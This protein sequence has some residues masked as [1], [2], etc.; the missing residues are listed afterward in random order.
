MPVTDAFW[1]L[2]NFCG[3][4]V[5]IGGFSAGL[6]RLLWR[7]DLARR[8]FLSLWAWAAMAALVAQTAGLVVFEHDGRMATYAAMVVA[9]AAAIWWAGF[10]AGKR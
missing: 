4:A 10:R 5:G 2:M 7:A 3:A 6:A 1:H 8:K 9:C